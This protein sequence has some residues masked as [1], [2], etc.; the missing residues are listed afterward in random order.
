[1]FESLFAFLFKY[2]P[3]VFEEG[4]FR[5]LAPGTTRTLVAVLAI[6]AAAAVITYA[7]A[8]ARASRRDRLVLAAVR[9]A[10]ILVLAFC[11]WDPALIVR[12][13]ERQ[14]NFLGILVDD[15]LSMRIADDDGVDR[16]TRVQE[17]LEENAPLRQALADRF[18][19]RF[20]QFN[21]DAR[22]LDDLRMLTFEGTRSRVAQAL[23]RARE[24]LAGL[25]L[26]GLVVVTD[27]A[28]NADEPLAELLPQLKAANVPV[29]TVGVGRETFARDIQLSEIETPRRV[30]KGT[31]LQVNVVLSQVG[32]AGDVV[33][34]EVQSEGRLISTQD[35]TLPGDGEP[36]TVRVRFTL[37]DPGPQVLD[38]RVAPRPDEMVTQ[39]NVRQVLLTVEDRREK[40]LYFEGEPRFEVKFLRRA[41]SDDENLQVVVLQRTA[42]NKFLRLD[43][44]DPDDLAAGFPR[45]RE[46]LFAYRALII[47]SVEASYFTADQLRMIADFVGERGGGFLM[48][49]GLHAFGEGGYVGTPVADVLPVILE[50]ADASDARF[51]ELHVSATRAGAAHTATQ[52]APSEDESAERWQALP[53]VSTLNQVV[54]LKPGATALLTGE[55]EEGGEEQVVLAYHRYGAGKAL[56]L[57]IQ[58]SWMWQMAADIPVDDMT[59]ELF[60]RRVLRWMVDGVPDQVTATI[61][62][63]RIEPGEP[64][65][66]VASVADRVFLETNSGRVTAEVTGPTGAVTEVPLE[67]TAEENGEYR[68]QFTASDRGLHEVLVTAT[69]DD[70]LLGSS[71]T[72]ALASPGDREFFDAGMRAGLLERLADDTGGRFYTTDT[73]SALPDDIEVVGGG[74]TI[75]EERELWDMPAVLLTLV[76]LLAAEWGFRRLRGLV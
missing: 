3:V 76:L 21:R 6:A 28:D 62:R 18:E 50:D 56:A 54:M 8:R 1:M 13:T 36:S 19:L 42:D 59:H 43:T 32:Y 33:A 22:R 44:E 49:G 73:V 53:P 58:D 5:F 61:T 11:L 24:E 67:W 46:E 63:D 7:G 37:T 64:A 12:S 57:S 10:I 55:D 71:R 2:R 34:L 45:T 68:G 72:F 29:F 14:Q 38:F 65:E 25:P 39:N 30:L 31:A 15:S 20:F 27:G 26:S 70:T 66:I 4:A 60:W 23:T 69:E 75:V 74:I 17:L 48:I 47:G 16:A 52:I 40:I 51:R 9:V 35:V 41:V